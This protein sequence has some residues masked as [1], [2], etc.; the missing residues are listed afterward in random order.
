MEKRKE[1]HIGPRD[2]YDN[3]AFDY[4]TRTYMCK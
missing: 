3:F 4:K 2:Y 1:I